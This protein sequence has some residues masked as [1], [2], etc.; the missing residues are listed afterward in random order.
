MGHGTDMVEDSLLLKTVP[1]QDFNRHKLALASPF[2][3]LPY[4]LTWKKCQT[5]FNP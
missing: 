5:H 4:H 1:S 3:R 2:Q